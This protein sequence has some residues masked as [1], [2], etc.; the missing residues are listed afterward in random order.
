MSEPAA[1]ARSSPSS[2]GDLV[3]FTSRAETL[4]PEDIEAFLQP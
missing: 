3:G 1:S 2:S 4:D